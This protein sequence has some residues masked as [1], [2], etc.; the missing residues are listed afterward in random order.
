[1]LKSN[2]SL[3]QQDIDQLRSRSAQTG[4]FWNDRVSAHIE[5]TH[6]AACISEC[7]SFYTNAYSAVFIA[8]EK[9]QLLKRLA[10]KY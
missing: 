3:L 10:D 1:M 8:E 7:S 6:I 2:L 9:E 4:Q 5:H